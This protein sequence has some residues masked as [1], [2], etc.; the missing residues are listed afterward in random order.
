MHEPRFE[1]VAAFLPVCRAARAAYH[2]KP[3]SREGMAFM[4][5]RER[6]ILSL[7][8]ELLTQS[9]R[10]RRYRIFSI[11]DP[12]PRMICAAAFRDRVVQH[13]LCD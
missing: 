13:A 10:P 2:G 5:E 11:A 6:E 8:N 7:E 9:Y 1:R 4:L 3:H 12:K